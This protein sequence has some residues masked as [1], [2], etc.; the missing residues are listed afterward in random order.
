MKK[1]LLALFLVSSALAFSARVVKSTETV[2][3]ENI[4]YVGQEK[5]PYTGVIENYND[6]GVLEAKVEFKDGKM[7]GSSKIYYPNGKLGS[8]ATFK[9][10]VQ[11]G[12]QKDYYENGKLKL[13]L[14]YKNGQIDGVAKAYDESGKVIQQATFKNG[15]QI[16]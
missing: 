1:L 10:N 11:V 3:K 12:V 15:E 9:D 2:V 16:K 4:V 7:N 5:T 8:E 6:K 13:E 14:P